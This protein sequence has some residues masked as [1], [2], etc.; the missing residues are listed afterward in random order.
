[1]KNLKSGSMDR[2]EHYSQFGSVKEFNYHIEMWLLETKPTFSK[3]ELIGLKRLIRF[4]AKI[5]GVSHAKIG[6]ILKAIHEEYHDHG[7][8]RSTFKRMIQKAIQLKSI[9][10]VYSNLLKEGSNKM[11]KRGKY[12]GKLLKRLREAKDITRQ[13][14]AFNCALGVSYMSKLERNIQEPS[15]G[16]IFIIASKL[17]IKASEFIEA[18]E[19]SE[20]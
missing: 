8:S 6:A 14:L 1:M 13:D 16:T 10:R 12:I 17:G 18:L 2:Y 4:S 5:P 7:I 19:D 3:G 11:K 15:L 20:E 9:Y